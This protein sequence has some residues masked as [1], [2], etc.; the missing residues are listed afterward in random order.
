MFCDFKIIKKCKITNGR[1]STFELANNILN[2]PVYMPVATYGAMRG[3]MVNKLEEDIILSNTYHLRNLNKN[4]KNFMGWKKSMLT[5]SGGFQIQSLPNV[6]VVDSGVIFGDKLFTPEES[7]EAQM[8]LGADIMMQLDDVVNPMERDELHVKAIARSIEWLDRAIIHIDKINTEKKKNNIGSI[9]G[10]NLKEG[11]K[12]NM[13][14]GAKN[15]QKEDVKNNNNKERKDKMR[16]NSESEVWKAV[17]LADNGTSNTDNTVNVTN[18][19]EEIIETTYNT[20]NGTYNT[21]EP[22]NNTTE[23]AM[24]ENTTEDSDNTVNATNNSIEQTC[25]ETYNETYNETVITDNEDSSSTEAEDNTEIVEYNN[26]IE[27]TVTTTGGSTDD[28]IKGNS[29]SETFE[30]TNCYDVKIKKMK[31]TK[32]IIK[33]PHIKC[34]NNQVLF[35][36][37]QGGL[38]EGLRSKSIKEIL[39]RKPKGLA[40]GGLSGGEDKNDFYRTVH[41]CCIKL[42]DGMPRYLMGVGYP[43]DIVV[44]C[45]LGTD[46]SDCV[47]P[48]RTARFGRAFC[49]TGDI[50][51]NN[52]MCEQLVPISSDCE[53]E[54]CKKYTRSYLALIKGSAI[55]CMIMSQHNLYY[56]RNLTRRIREAILADK[57]PEFICKFMKMRYQDKI[58]EAIVNALKL[59]N[60]TL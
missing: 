38:I 28:A 36:I 56:M 3:V 9:N 60:I 53:C 34:W 43:E 16:Y 44:C 49:D 47:Y 41:T 42:P 4:V 58:P 11:A 20:G 7:M 39:L 29:S 19:T 45:A 52:A 32:N 24:G 37:I 27:T 26:N 35:P 13:K 25:N 23:D 15:N 59:V 31:K 6:K 46:M 17:D 2:L 30:A 40:I 50:V 22:S 51:I 18:N 33:I 48:T 8:M 54:T 10:N 5:D 14:E 57:F 12:N 1:V 21:T 55:F